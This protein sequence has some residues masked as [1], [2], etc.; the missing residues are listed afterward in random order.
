MPNSHYTTIETIVKISDIIPA[1]INNNIYKPVDIN[2][3]DI[4]KMADDIEK[5]G[6]LEPIVITLDNVILSG[7]RRHGAIRRL[8]W[9]FIKVRQENIESTSPDFVNLLTSHNY[10][11]VKSIDEILRETVINNS[12][13]DS[14]QE[15]KDY[16]IK[17]SKTDLEKNM[18]Q[19]A[20]FNRNRKITKRTRPFLNKVLHIL[21]NDLNDFLPVSVRQIHYNL[22]NYN[23]LT[24]NSNP[25]S[26]YINND[27]C[28]NKLVKLISK[29]RFSK[30]I[31]FEYIVDETRPVALNQFDNNADEFVDRNINSFLKDYWRNLTQSQPNHIEVVAEKMT[32]KSIINSV[33]S[34]YCIPCT[35][36][37]G[38]SSIRPI[39]DIKCRFEKSGKEKLIVLFLTDFDPDGQ[40]IATAL[41][42]TLQEFGISPVVHKVG[43]THEQFMNLDARF[44]FPVKTTS[45]RSANFINEYGS[46]V[47][48]L[49]ALSPKQIQNILR[50]SIKSALD[51][52]LYNQEVELE[53]KDSHELHIKREQIVN[54]M[55]KE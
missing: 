34:D 10:Q 3:P 30:F 19:D 6:L 40:G 15:L 26:K 5:N 16:R 55:R 14:Y 20:C 43:I 7:H 11:R 38:Y 32:L 22:L 52:D 36:G 28:Y 37:R 8:G 1:G 2:A 54:L 53:K 18:N 23:V 31:P 44:K 47:A 12:E 46:L 33:C 41:T 39:Y 35:I 27:K 49:E 51:I 24:D 48:E 45:S 29:A 21:E 13:N 17:Q 50:D 42:E 9:D 4:V 25:E